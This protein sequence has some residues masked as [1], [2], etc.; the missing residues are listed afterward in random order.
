MVKLEVNLS[1][2]ESVLLSKRLR[3]TCLYVG[4]GRDER[5]VGG[6]P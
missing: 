3:I 4:L 2:L 6:Q 1:N 5:G